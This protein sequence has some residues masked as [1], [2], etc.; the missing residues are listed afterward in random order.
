MNPAN[1]DFRVTA[2]GRVLVARETLDRESTATYH[3]TVVA[4]DS[5]KPPLSA[6][7]QVSQ[8]PIQVAQL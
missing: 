7:A 1:Q 8:K 2:D 5:G 3:F 4:I 6:T